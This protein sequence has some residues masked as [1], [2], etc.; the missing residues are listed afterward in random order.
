MTRRSRRRSSSA[1]RRAQSQRRPSRWQ[2]QS[3]RRRPWRR[4]ELARVSTAAGRSAAT[5]RAPRWRRGCHQ[6]TATARPCCRRWACRRCVCPRGEAVRRCLRL[7]VARARIGIG[8]RPTFLLRTPPLPPP[9]PCI[10]TRIDT[11]DDLLHTQASPLGCC[12]WR[13]ARWPAGDWRRVG[14]SRGGAPYWVHASPRACARPTPSLPCPPT[15]AQVEWEIDPAEIDFSAAVA[16][17][18]G[19]YGEV[20]R[21]KWRGLPVAIKRCAR[22]GGAGGRAR[23]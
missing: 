11:D 4:R 3:G 10:Q 9:T 19:A 16:L 13:C 2:R 1:A 5:R 15:N 17:G 7:C 18:K 14:P 6:T 12:D 8:V 22:G 20:V 23:W 21:A